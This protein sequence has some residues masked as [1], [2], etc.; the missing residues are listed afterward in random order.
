MHLHVLLFTGDEVGEGPEE[1]ITISRYVSDGV[2]VGRCEWHIRSTQTQ[3]D[4]S[5][6]L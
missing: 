1:T 2:V 5:A 6:E 3:M 4:V